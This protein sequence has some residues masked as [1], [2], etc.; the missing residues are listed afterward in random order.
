MARKST[1]KPIHQMSIRDFERIFPDEDACK[2]YLAEH[3]WPEFVV[4]PRCGN[5]DV[6]P[7]A[8]P[9][10]WV[11]D[12]CTPGNNYRFSELVGT[13]F[14]NSKFDLRQWFRVIHLMLTSKKAISILQ[15]H[16]Y[17]GFGS[18]STAWYICNRIRV[19]LANEDFRKLTGIAN[20]NESFAA[21]RQRTG[22]EPS[23]ARSTRTQLN[24]SGPLRN[25]DPD[26]D[27]G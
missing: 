8:R 24:A 10:H 9:F 19:G 27:E 17:L 16:R 3:R 6:K 7:H 2:R 5:A 23:P 20:V 14:E 21:A 13:I 4:C 12:A 15:V 26:P 1:G 25:G 22:I 18:Y 11:C